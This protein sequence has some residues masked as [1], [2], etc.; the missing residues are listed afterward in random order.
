MQRHGCSRVVGL[1]LLLSLAAVL[2]SDGKQ[3]VT[4]ECFAEFMRDLLRVTDG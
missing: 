3:S 1:L 4:T 2:A